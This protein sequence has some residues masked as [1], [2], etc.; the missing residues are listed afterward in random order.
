MEKSDLTWIVNQVAGLKNTV[1]TTVWATELNAKEMYGILHKDGVKINLFHTNPPPGEKGLKDLVDNCNFRLQDQE[2]TFQCTLADI[3]MLLVDCLLRGIGHVPLTKTR[4]RLVFLQSFQ[5]DL[6][7]GVAVPVVPP[8]AASVK[9]TV[10]TSVK[11]YATTSYAHQNRFGTDRT[12]APYV[13]SSSDLAKTR[14]DTI[15]FG[16]ELGEDG[17]SQ[18]VLRRLGIVRALLRMTRKADKSVFYIALVQ[19]LLPHHE[20]Q[21][22]VALDGSPIHPGWPVPLMFDRVSLT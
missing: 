14:F 9:P 5:V 1:A 6:L 10:N 2:Q 15:E 21:D 12:G 17:G 18:V 19:P 13:S 16:S 4:D 8:V 20:T 11:V 3:R 22:E 7:Q